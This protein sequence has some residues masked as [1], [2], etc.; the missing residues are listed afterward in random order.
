MDNSILNLALV[1]QTSQHP[2]VTSDGSTAKGRSSVEERRGEEMRRLFPMHSVG[3]ARE[4]ES[5]A[6]R[7]VYAYLA[8]AATNEDLDR[9]A[10]FPVD[11]PTQ[12]IRRVWLRDQRSVLLR[13]VLSTDAAKLQSFVRSMSATTRRNRFHGAL[14]DLPEHRLRYMTEVDYVN[15]LAFIGEVRDQAEPRQ[16]AEARWFRRVDEPDCADFAIAIDDHYQSGGLGS[17]LMEVLQRS[18]AAKDIRQ[19]C[20]HVLKSNHRMIGWLEAHGW[21]KRHDPYD[22]GVVQVELPLQRNGQ[23]DVVASD[24]LAAAA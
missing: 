21:T 1:S 19:L 5:S 6:A 8:E 20:G 16:V 17:L 2:S 23:P 4:R 22:P 9:R 14:V 12:W 18:A 7:E 10:P 15:H 24:L 13:P 11:Y 3:R